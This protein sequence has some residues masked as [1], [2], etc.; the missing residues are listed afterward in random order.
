MGT[1]HD[2]K[3]HVFT[4]SDVNLAANIF[5]QAILKRFGEIWSPKSDGQYTGKAWEARSVLAFDPGTWRLVEAAIHAGAIRAFG[6]IEKR[7]AG[8]VLRFIIFYEKAK[9]DEHH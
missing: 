1:I 5:E 3:S 6:K 9:P 7:E 8:T 4:R 2:P